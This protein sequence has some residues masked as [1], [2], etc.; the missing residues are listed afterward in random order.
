MDLLYMLQK[1]KLKQNNSLYHV[2]MLHMQFYRLSLD[3]Q[4]DN[5][6]HMN[7][8]YIINLGKLKEKKPLLK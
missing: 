1:E 3:L 4:L 7:L 8:S 6:R 2:G 5:T